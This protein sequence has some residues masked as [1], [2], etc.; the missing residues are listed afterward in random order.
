MWRN[1]TF[2]CHPGTAGFSELLEPPG[3][4]FPFRRT[5]IFLSVFSLSLFFFPPSSPEIFSSRLSTVFS[6]GRC[7]SK[8][9]ID[10]RW[11]SNNSALILETVSTGVVTAEFG[12]VFFASG[13][14][15]KKKEKLQRSKSQFSCIFFKG[16]ASICGSGR[17]DRGRRVR[18][19]VYIYKDCLSSA[20][21]S[22]ALGRAQR[23]QVPSYDGA[24]NKFLTGDSIHSFP[25]SAQRL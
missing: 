5:F 25:Q 15:K 9:F 7:C 6:S 11:Y 22:R 18:W 1:V 20:L 12:L 14:K 3:D 2:K 17:T 10:P 21:Y 13:K 19:W 24:G 8:A 4:L 16:H 23:R